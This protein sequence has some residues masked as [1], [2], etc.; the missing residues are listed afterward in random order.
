MNSLV[1]KSGKALALAGALLTVADLAQPIAPISSYVLMASLVGLLVLAIIRFMLG[2]W[3][4]NLSVL[5]Y[6]SVM[7]LA[8]SL[9][10]FS[11][12]IQA[13]DS[14]QNGL[15]SASFKGVKELQS[16]LGFIEIQVTEIAKSTKSIEKSTKS[17]DKK[18]DNVK[19]EISTNPRK[20]LA[21]MGLSWS[22]N[23]FNESLVRADLQAI[24]LYIKGG[25]KLSGKEFTQFVSKN[26]TQKVA[27]LL[28]KNNAI[29]NDSGCPTSSEEMKFYLEAS[30]EQGRSKLVRKICS[31][32]RVI[33]ELKREKK[34]EL[35]KFGKF[36]VKTQGQLG[37]RN[38]CI[39]RYASW[40]H[41]RLTFFFEN[42]YLRRNSNDSKKKRGLAF[43][44]VLK[45]IAND[46]S[47]GLYS[48]SAEK[49]KH[50][51]KVKFRS[52][53]SSI[54][55]SVY[56]VDKITNVKIANIDKVIKYLR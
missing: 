1:V 5:S 13:P 54:C 18:I 17:I 25:M 56:K 14:K 30:R 38:K 8:L 24:S 6:F 19:K 42:Y 15:L 47:G 39:K 40:D 36:R 53:Y 28:L 44:K 12:Q 9:I 33:I 20:E 34:L 41:R 3:N 35:G 37:E 7:C 16:S 43:E 45:M 51:L 32:Q 48:K 46:K 52:M 22:Y 29:R 27:Q 10:L 11:V 2:R 31:T 23:A 26:Y 50:F 49:R 4:D 21:N 55:A